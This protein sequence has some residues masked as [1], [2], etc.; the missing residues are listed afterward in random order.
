MKLVLFYMQDY[1][2]PK[3]KVKKNS[4]KN[5]KDELKKL[6]Q[7]IVGPLEIMELF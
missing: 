5:L 7:F 4:K 3:F 2:I 6:L 1:F